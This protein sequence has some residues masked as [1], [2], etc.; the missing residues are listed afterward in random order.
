MEIFK[1]ASEIEKVY[2][3]LID[4]AKEASFAEL[5]A[6]RNNQEKMT[7]YAIN[8]K[9]ELV[10]LALKNLSEEVDKRINK[11]KN[12]LN[13]VIKNIEEKYQKN[14]KNLQKLIIEDLGLDF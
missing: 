7:E 11:Y 4:D 10:N 6:L 3:D 5:Q 9:R 14:K 12:E 13:N 8:Q 1:W 2:K